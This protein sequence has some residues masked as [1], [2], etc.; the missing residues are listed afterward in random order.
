V[1]LG[2]SI[3][4][5]TPGYERFDYWTTTE[6]K[7]N[8]VLQEKSLVLDNTRIN[9]PPGDGEIIRI[10]RFHNE[11]DLIIFIGVYRHAF[12]TGRSRSGGY[13]SAGVWLSGSFLDGAII[14]PVIRDI[15]R[16]TERACCRDSEFISRLERSSGVFSD[17]LRAEY[18][19][20]SNK[21]VQLPPHIAAAKLSSS[22]LFY[23]FSRL[24]IGADTFFINF[25]QASRSH[26]AL[27][28][29]YLTTS[30]SVVEGTYRAGGIPIFNEFDLARREL[31]NP[32]FPNPQS[33]HSL[34]E[35]PSMPLGPN[36]TSR[37][38]DA[39]AFER[40]MAKIGAIE[41]RLGGLIRARNSDRKIVFIW[42]TVTS[43]LAAVIAGS[44]LTYLAYKK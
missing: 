1:L 6:D 31:G 15:L 9:I 30:K 28:D 24:S 3:S 23:D 44:I 7:T 39:Y 43:F 36:T 37:S 32:D 5:V 42:I 27:G 20:I 8:A 10:R 41:Q 2:F 14:L 25:L 40:V 29:I 12:E 21:L 33:V 26:S 35:E 22:F 4:G 19:N 38:V 11:R 17:V 34:N 16:S 13:M 18:E